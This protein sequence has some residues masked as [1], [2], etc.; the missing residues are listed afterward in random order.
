[1]YGLLQFFVPYKYWKSGLNGERKVIANISNK[2]GS[3]HSLFNDV[4]LRDGKSGGNIDHIVVGPR[5]IFVIE[6]KNIQGNFMIYED[7]WKG[8]KQ[9]PSSQAKNNSRLHNFLNYS[10]VLDRQLPYVHAIVVLTNNKAIPIIKKL[11]E[12]C[13]IIQIKNQ[14]DSHLYDYIMHHEGEKFFQ[15]KK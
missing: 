7:N 15:L 2:L 11:P 9:S 12:M 14:E 3:E 4:M 5:G 1:M 8:L 13:E 6:T 10:R